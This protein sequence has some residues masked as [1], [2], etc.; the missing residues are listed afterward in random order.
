MP[1]KRFR[2]GNNNNNKRRDRKKNES[3]A[4]KPPFLQ[5]PIILDRRERSEQTTSSPIS[6][7]TILHNDAD[8]TPLTKVEPLSSSSSSLGEANASTAATCIPFWRRPNKF[9]AD[10]ILK[11]LTDYPGHFVIGIIG[12]QGVGKS[13]ILSH[14]TQD[15]EHAFP[16]Q[17][18]DQFLYQGHKTNG[19][20]M[21][22]TPERAILLDT[23][24]ILS[25]TVL[26]T[27]LGQGSLG[28][29]HPDVWL[30]MESLYNLIFLMSVCNSVLVV[31]DGPEMDMDVLK[32]IQRAEMLKFCIPDFPLLVGQQQDM[33]HYPEMVF[34]CNKCQKSE[35]TYR[36]YSA[37][38]AVLTSF[39]ETSQLKTRGLV[40]L[41]DILPLYKTS[42][43]NETN[44][45]FLPQQD[46]IDSLQ[47]LVS[48]LRDQVLAGPR[49]PG[50]K[51]QVSEKDW[52]RNAIKTYDVVRKSDYINEYLQVVQ[53]HPQQ[54]QQQRQDLSLTSI[55]RAAQQ[56]NA[57]T[58]VRFFHQHLQKASTTEIDY[59]LRKLLSYVKH[60]NEQWPQKRLVRC[61]DCIYAHAIK[62]H[63]QER[64]LLPSFKASVRWVVAMLADETTD[65]NNNNNDPQAAAS[66]QI[67]CAT[68]FICG[69]L[70][71]LATATATSTSTPDT[72]AAAT[73]IIAEIRHRHGVK[74]LLGR[75]H[76]CPL[77]IRIYSVRA[78]ASQIKYFAKDMMALNAHAT[79]AQSLFSIPNLLH[80][81][82][83]TPPVTDAAQQRNELD[84][85]VMVCRL[86]ESLF[87]YDL[88]SSS[89]SPARQQFAASN[90]FGQLLSVWLAACQHDY[91][92]T[93]LAA[94]SSNK[95]LDKRQRVLVYS[96]TSIVQKCTFTNSPASGRI[97]EESARAKWQPLL[98]LCMQR[99]IRGTCCTMNTAVLTAAT[100][101]Q[102]KSIL[103]K[104]V[105]ISLAILPVLKQHNYWLDYVDQAVCDL[106]NFLMAYVSQPILPE[107]ASLVGTP[108]TLLHTNLCIDV[109]E[110]GYQIDGAML[111]QQHQDLFVLLLES[112]IQHVQLASPSFVKMVSGRVAWCLKSMLTI[113]LNAD[114]LETSALRSRLLKLIVFFLHYDDAIHCFATASTNIAALVFGPT[115]ETAKQGLLTA[116]SLSPAQEALTA[117]QSVAIYKAKRAFVSLAMISKHP[118]ACERL[119]DCQVLQLVDVALIPR[120]GHVIE[121]TASLLSVYALFGQFVAALSRRTAFVRTRL[122]D[123]C[124]LIPMIMK[125]LQE[126]VPLKEARRGL[127]ED[128]HQD[129]IFKGWNHV[130][131]SCLMVISTFQYDEPSMRMW[132]SWDNST[133]AA[134]AADAN[135]EKEETAMLIDEY[136]AAANT[137]KRLSILP[138][139]LSILFPWRNHH[140]EEDK[141]K[142]T[143][144]EI[145]RFLKPDLQVVLLAS[146]LLD[147]LSVIPICGRQMIADPTALHNLCSL[148][149]CLTAAY[150]PDQPEC[151]YKLTTTTT[152]GNNTDGTTT[153]LLSMQ[154]GDMLVEKLPT[155]TV[156][157]PALLD[158]DVDMTTQAHHN[159][160]TSI[161][162]N[163]HL[164]L[165]SSHQEAAAA[166]AAA[167]AAVQRSR[168]EP[169]N[170]SCADHLRRAAVRILITHDNMQFT[171]L[172]DAFTA[173]FQPVLQ[174]PVRGTSHEY[175]RRLVC[176][177]LFEKKMDDFLS[178]FRFT[179]TA[180]N[181]IKLHEMAAIAVGY[182]AMGASSDEAWNHILGLVSL[183]GWCIVGSKQPFGIFC[184]M[185]VYELEYEEEEEDQEEVKQ[186]QND[187]LLLSMITPFRRHAAA[188]VLE[189]L[190]LDFEVLWKVE[191][192]SI[193]EHITLPPHM[194]LDQP[195]QVV[196]FVTDDVTTS[197]ISGNRQLL[198]ARSP[199]FDA[200]L[201][202]DYAESKLAA[203]P[204]HD[205]TFHSLKLFISVIHQLNDKAE[206]RRR[207]SH[208]VDQVL[209]PST[210]WNDIVDLLLISDRFGSTVVKS[211]CEHWILEQVKHMGSSSSRLVCLEGMVG[212][213][214]QC[215]DPMEKDGGIAS[216]T[217]P[218]ATIL[219]EV[220]KT[221]LQ[222]MS[223]SCQTASF[224]Q[225]IQDK[226]VEELD[227]FCNG[228]AYL[229]QK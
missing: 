121:K 166:A 94:D 77:P 41:G 11:T 185:L 150:C 64:V 188:Q 101:E 49:R 152:T 45:F 28:G 105:Q 103:K 81:L 107:Q 224:V 108:S 104:L 131:A 27:A 37:L 191:T 31:N 175:W 99:W 17:D 208:L 193:R 76:G 70:E 110:R 120:S 26:D 57:S 162:D 43:A 59:T 186:Q 79:L 213:Y 154:D 109:E 32:L 98:A 5:A 48:A 136:T 4:G 226:R 102:D 100:L 106:T 72:E 218:F 58:S 176:D 16:N 117:E 1:D 174:H 125:L 39:F 215:C 15:P 54:Q 96:L 24:P 179:E 113:L 7:P 165:D 124:N 199:I 196:A 201:S 83:L 217:W 171:M 74:A 51:G 135:E 229:L 214:R 159:D 134:A 114:Q 128:N 202:T 209:A 200:L 133:A 221:I 139:L 46:D 23:E 89:S 184:Q 63:L 85:C 29:L 80:V 62:P 205:V 197:T 147:Q 6:A 119:V 225:M 222:Y 55:Y 161:L 56:P 18:N 20:D 189:T 227:V 187:T 140:M 143:F 75:T 86:L 22:M 71:D 122:R 148:M 2:D 84:Q 170:L 153:T 40:S 44:L 216:E 73:A 61:L 132:L 156:V 3:S 144:A 30:E 35:F 212:L 204:L 53:R 88:A 34:V 8:T 151:M 69:L 163:V 12:K 180:D 10:A 169:P 25:W 127:M 195:A 92:T 126:A 194:P 146:Q 181:A 149:I 138:I 206:T 67:Q 66:Q 111:N 97:A 118:R 82:S 115:I 68:K 178:L 220:L 116:V 21:Y 47:D 130:I 177:D 219:R 14:F 155:T 167:A 164:D 36:N 145:N 129:A 50:K 33:H 158:V 9:N 112:L 65:S 91:K 172:S 141:N 173:F 19:I 42:Q 190:A 95:S 223:E 52:F 142:A 137:P 93:S 211:L 157:E 13:T 198:R 160:A 203:I 90:A 207:R 210:S 38:Q 78:L 228:L 168:Q 183:D 87:K 60:N 182:A 192:E 123:E